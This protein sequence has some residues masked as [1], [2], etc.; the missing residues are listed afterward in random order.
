V[1]EPAESSTPPVAQAPAKPSAGVSLW[2]KIFGSPAEQAAKLTEEVASSEF[3]EVAESV[4]EVESAW[5]AVES[6]RHTSPS[7]EVES[8]GT[9]DDSGDSE[10]SESESHDEEQ[11]E[12]RPRRPRRRR[13]GRGSRGSESR[14]EQQAARSSNRRS[15]RSDA[16]R[17][18]DDDFDDLGV[19]TDDDELAQEVSGD[20]AEDGETDGE[21]SWRSSEGRGHRSIPSWEQ[22][23]GMIVD[24]N[25]QSRSQRRQTS[26]TGSRGGSSRGGRA[27]G[28]R[29]RSRS[30]GN[31]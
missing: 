9:R 5:S 24:A 3:T 23:I 27:R 8:F 22:A 29:R 16:N 26:S 25:L 13:R 11:A 30:S 15:E 14:G 20:D 12:Q 19:E 17:G 7:G 4:T 31:E 28:G 1:I 2:H 18:P 21:S 6:S 10:E